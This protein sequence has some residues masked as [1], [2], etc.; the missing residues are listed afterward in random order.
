M[1]GG[2]IVLFALASVVSEFVHV[3][4]STKQ[5]RSFHLSHIDVGVLSIVLYGIDL[6]VTRSFR[7]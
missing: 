3:V 6:L 7:V 1:P 2:G 5:E 4:D